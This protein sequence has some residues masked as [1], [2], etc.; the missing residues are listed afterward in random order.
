VN[1]WPS[2]D[3]EQTLVSPTFGNRSVVSSSIS[4]WYYSSDEEEGS[5]ASRGQY[6]AGREQ[7]G[8]AGG[9][10]ASESVFRPTL[11]PRSH[12]TSDRDYYCRNTNFSR[13]GP[14]R[15]IGS[16]GNGGAASS[17]ENSE[18]QARN[19]EGGSNIATDGS[20]SS[21]RDRERLNEFVYQHCVRLG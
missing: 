14:V 13:T 1:G 5:V 17:E 10:V 8:R 11:A 9:D 21:E 3:S 12:Y 6:N 18:L 16:S 19:D 4:D 2:N 15:R 20:G 7:Q